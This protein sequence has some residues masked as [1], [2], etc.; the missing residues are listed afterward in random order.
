MTIDE[1]GFE[2]EAVTCPDEALPEAVETNWLQ[3][4]DPINADQVIA[5][6]GVLPAFVYEPL[7]NAAP[8]SVRPS[9]VELTQLL[10]ELDRACGVDVETW[11]DALSRLLVVTSGLETKLAD[12]PPEDFIGSSPARALG[13]SLFERTLFQPGCL[14]PDA[15]PIAVDDPSL[16]DLLALTSTAS[17]SVAE[18]D[19]LL[20]GSIMTRLFHFYSALPAY[21]WL[22]NPLAPVDLVVLGSSQAGAAIE[23]S[24]LSSGLGVSVGNAFL[25]GSLAEVQQ[26]WVPEVYRYASPT[27]I[28]WLM[29][30]VDLLGTCITPGRA[31]QFS[32]R[33]ANR[34]M[35]F[36]ASGWFAGVDNL[37]ILL[38]RDTGFPNANMGNAPKGNSRN[39]DAIA[40]QI[41]DYT[42]QFADPTFCGDRAAVTAEVVAQLQAWGAEVVIVGMTVSPEAVE[43]IPGGRETIA[44]SFD[45]LEREV[46]APTGATFVDLSGDLDD[47]G[48]WA[49]LTHLN[50][51][52]ASRFT[53]LLTKRFKERGIGP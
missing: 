24:D 41:P 48:L 20:S 16:G 19:R 33:L 25:P 23:V 28:V 7:A 8:E 18:V 50:Q 49:D 36:A 29:G 5:M 10:D 35:T 40:A 53:Q 6:E 2:S 26:L 42:N 27:T 11:R 52:G 47:D 15:L 17:A 30:P 32:D 1:Y 45:Q 3:P 38:G 31:E 34:Q 22:R 39:P 44:A 21:R 51:A 14:A 43:L 4:G 37:D 46:I 9:F 13:R 12:S